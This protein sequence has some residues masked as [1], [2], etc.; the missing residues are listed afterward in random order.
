MKHVATIVLLALTIAVC[1]PHD[2]PST[3][4]PVIA[5]AATQDSPCCVSC[6]K[7]RDSA[8]DDEDWAD[9]QAL[10]ACAK[11][12]YPGCVDD[13]N[14]AHQFIVASIWYAYYNCM[15]GCPDG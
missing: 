7:D 11:H 3:S 5:E 1:A 8:L 13:V 15:L 12:P 14:T 4:V 6:A 10:A 9:L 2:P